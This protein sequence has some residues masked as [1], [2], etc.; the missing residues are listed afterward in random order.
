MANKSL[1]VGRDSRRRIVL[2]SVSMESPAVTIRHELTPSA[3]ERLADQLYELAADEAENT[4]AY[5]YDRAC[6]SAGAKP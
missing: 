5:A 6:E 2:D 1:Y 4:L 3:A